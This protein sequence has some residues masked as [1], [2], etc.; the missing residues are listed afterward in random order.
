MRVALG[1]VML[2]TALLSSCVLMATLVPL[3]ARAQL[4]DALG[5]T[6][7]ESY[8]SAANGDQPGE[9]QINVFRASAGVPLPIADETTL[10]GGL[11]YELVDVRPSESGSFQLHAPSRTGRTWIC[12]PRQLFIAAMSCSRTTR[13]WRVTRCRASSATARA[14]G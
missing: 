4:V 14:S 6:S 11:S 5:A 2:K 9:T 12:T 10:I 3:S 13:A 1:A 7:L 8:P